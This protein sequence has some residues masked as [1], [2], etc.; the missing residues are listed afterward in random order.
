MEHVTGNAGNRHGVDTYGLSDDP[1]DIGSN[2][3]YGAT[4]HVEVLQPWEQSEQ[5]A[6]APAPTGEVSHGGALSLEQLLSAHG[7]S[8]HY[9]R[10][11]EQGASTI[12]DL[13][14]M[15]KEEFE[16]CGFKSL[17]ANRMLR[18]LGRPNR[19]PPQHQQQQQQQQQPMQQS[20]HIAGMASVPMVREQQHHQQQLHYQHAQ[21]QQQ[22]QLS[23][24]QQPQ[25]QQQQQQ[26]PMGAM[27][28]PPT[29]TMPQ[30]Q[31]PATMQPQAYSVDTTT[32]ALN[33]GASKPKKG[34]EFIA[35]PAVD[36]LF[37]LCACCCARYSLYTDFPGCC[38]VT[39]KNE[40]VCQKNKFQVRYCDWKPVCLYGHVGGS[41]MDFRSDKP[42]LDS[43]C[44]HSQNDCTDCCS[45]TKGMF[46]CAKPTTLC[47]GATVCLC[48]DSRGAF[49]CDD[50]VPFQI[51]LCGMMCVVHKPCCLASDDLPG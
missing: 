40:C 5:Q 8:H 17:E 23:Q 11:L 30:Q 36:Q 25:Q 29:M 13:D 42:T 37:T 24:Q 44:C 43:G 4:G 34:E 10:L 7:L 3:A 27:A 6:P 20:E 31:Q 16:E 28:G 39:L 51:G 21:Q 26:Q 14:G 18:A 46:S 2:P 19:V 48:I 9:H 49:P 15:Q 12:E 45:H 50:E 38:G 22:P 32:F 35:L 47:K 1:D 33:L 41:C